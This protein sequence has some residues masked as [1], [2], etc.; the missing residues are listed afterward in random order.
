MPCTEDVQAGNGLYNNKRDRFER[1]TSRNFKGV[2]YGMASPNA[3]SQSRY[4]EEAGT[5]LAIMGEMAPQI[6]LDYT[7]D[8]LQRLDQ[9]ISEHFD[10]PGAKFVD[11]TLPVGIGC[12]VGEVIIRHIGGH[13]NPE[14]KPEINEIGP[15]EAIQPIEKARQRFEQGREHSLSWYYHAI[16]KQAYE[17]DDPPQR[18]GNGKGG[19]LDMI[20]GIFKK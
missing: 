15:L 1:W 12:Y 6:G 16:Q 20:M 2:V 8:S 4:Q 13:W 18:N 5:F 9:F 17:G 14:G 3:D 19:L 11:E 10:P 7:V